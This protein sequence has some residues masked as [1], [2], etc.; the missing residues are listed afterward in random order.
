M[1][2][3]QVCVHES[4]CHSACVSLVPRCSVQEA[5]HVSLCV[6]VHVHVIAYMYVWVYYVHV[7][8]CVHMC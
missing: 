7:S 4:E 5:M 1:Q 2:N 3:S 8:V 6:H